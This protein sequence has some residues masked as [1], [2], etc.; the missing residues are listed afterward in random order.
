MTTLDTKRYGLPRSSAY[1]ASMDLALVNTEFETF[2]T[3]QRRTY[4]HNAS[5]FLL[6]WTLPTR[7]AKALQ[8]WLLSLPQGEFFWCD[9][10]SGNNSNATRNEII[11]PVQIRRTSVITTERVPLVDKFT[12]S[13]EAET[14][15][16]DGY[17]E[18]AQAAANQ[19]PATYP[20]N[21]PLPIATGF[22]SAHSVRNTTVYTLSYRM[23]TLT[24]QKWLAFAGYAGT[25][26]FFHPMISTNVPCG[27]E[28][29]RYVTNFEQDLVGPDT[30]QVTVSAETMPGAAILYYDMPPTGEC[31]YNSDVFYDE[32]D[33]PYECGG[34]PPPQGN[35]VTPAGQAVLTAAAVGAAPQTAFT[36]IKFN[37]DGSVSGV[38]GII[39]AWT[40]WHT[41]PTTLPR[42]AVS[43]TEVI[44]FSFDDGAT[45]RTSTPVPGGFWMSLKEHNVWLR[46]VLTGTYN[47]TENFDFTL[48]FQSDVAPTPVPIS[49]AQ[50]SVRMSLTLDVTGG[51]GGPGTGQPTTGN[52]FV[53]GYNYETNNPGEDVSVSAGVSFYPNGQVYGASTNEM[54]GLWF[55]PV[56]T[57]A[58]APLWIILTKNSGNANPN[59]I[60]TGVRMSMAG[61]LSFVVYSKPSVAGAY[62][63][64]FGTYQIWNAQSGGTMLGSGFIELE[65]SI[66]V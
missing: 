52:T 9:L 30:W 15:A 54:L 37:T 8:D 5:L 23:N 35:F 61:V 18:L 63:S 17:T 4:V 39:P 42:P 22:S 41:A 45:W 2:W 13:F 25:A 51:G 31:T 6:S 1:S 44:E 32:P 3:R 59:Q 34:V 43:C 55:D 11:A 62:I 58:G 46:R 57:N 12:L 16:L 27:L 21:L 48:N 47:Q 24:L 29:L 14:M 20:R 64:W 50:A 36:I 60:Q 53:D 19:P 28:M 7:E 49:S 40:A 66:T 33:H 65:S 26:W 10:L 56:T 38:P